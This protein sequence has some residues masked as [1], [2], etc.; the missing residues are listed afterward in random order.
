MLGRMKVSE[1]GCIQRDERV[2][3]AALDRGIPLVM[4]TSGGYQKTN[5]RVIARSIANLHQ[6]FNLF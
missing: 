5:A 6:T 2:F 1:D 3:R 4:V